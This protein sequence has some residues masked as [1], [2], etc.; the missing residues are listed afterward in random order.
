LVNETPSKYLTA[1]STGIFK[2]KK[3]Q[4]IAFCKF[5][6]FIQKQ[7]KLNEKRLAGMRK[8]CTNGTLQEQLI[9]YCN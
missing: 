3:M 2:K 7:A 5:L 9:K 1:V 8:P 6:T 4:Y